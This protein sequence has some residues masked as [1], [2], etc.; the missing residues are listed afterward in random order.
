MA[1]ALPWNHSID[2]IDSWLHNFSYGLADLNKH[3]DRVFLP[4]DDL[5]FSFS[6]FYIVPQKI[7]FPLE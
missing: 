1:M 5:S 6:D 3:L 7:Q 4:V 2:A